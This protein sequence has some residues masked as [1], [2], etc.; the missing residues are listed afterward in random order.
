MVPQDILALIPNRECVL[1]L[2]A[3]CD[4]HAETETIINDFRGLRDHRDPFFLE[5]ND[6]ERVIH[7]KLR[8]QYQRQARRR[9]LN[10]D[11]VVHAITAAA[12]S[13]N[14]DDTMYTVELKVNI[15][16]AL[17]G[18]SVPV[19]SAALALSYPESYCTVDFRIMDLF[20]DAR[21]VDFPS[22]Y[23]YLDCIRIISAQFQ[24]TPMQLD[25]AL[26]QYHIIHNNGN[27]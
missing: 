1:Q 16:S 27:G 8:N 22:Y 4:D 12:F 5:F 11:A 18:V 6:L 19:A 23:N 9:Q 20:F 17:R 26:W 25:I 7:W 10:N 24:I 2:Y 21:Q 3:Q 15:L 13:I 14:H